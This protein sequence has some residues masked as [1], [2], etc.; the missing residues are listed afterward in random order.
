MPSPFIAAAL[1]AQTATLAVSSPDHRNEIAISRDGA[2]FSIRRDGQPVIATSPLGIELADRPAWARMTLSRRVDRAVDRNVRLVAGKSAIARDHYRQSLLTFRE[3]DG[4]RRTITLEIR[5]YDDGIALRYLMTGMSSAEVTGERTAF[6]IGSR[7][8]CLVSKTTGPHEAKFFPARIGSLAAGVR[9]D[10]PIVCTASSGRIGYAIAQADLGGY[11]GSSLV[12]DGDTLKV[13]LS[14]VPGRAQ[15]VVRAD[16]D[17]RSAWRVIMLADRPGDLIASNLIGN[18]NP[19][20]RGD[21]S[22]VRPGKAAWDWWSGPL[23]GMPA[24]MPN[25]RRFIDFAAQNRLPY[26]LIDAGWAL[27]AGPCCDALPTTDI[28]QAAPGVDMP[29][30]VRYARGRSVKLLLWVHWK[31]LSERMD[32][33]LDTYQHW[34]IAGVKVDFMERD[35]EEMV[36]FYRKLAAA[37]AR[38][39]LLLD[40]HAAY[41]PDGL[42][43]TFPNFI[44]Q[45]G[46]LGAEYNK[47][48]SEVT[49]SHN[50]SLAYTRMLLGPMDYTPGGMRSVAPGDFTVRDVAPLVKTTRGQALAMYVVY[51]SPL[52]MVADSPD[53]YAGADGFD[54]IRSVPTAWDE[55]R[56]LAGETGRSIVLARRKGS[57]WYIGAMT[58]ETPR[59]INVPLTFLAPG[60]YR[61]TIWQDSDRPTAVTRSVRDVSR[62]DELS[63]SLAGSGGAAT[64]LAPVDQVG[65]AGKPH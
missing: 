61:A 43:R 13:D 50:V 2:T 63:L 18:L 53:A 9:Y 40:L 52:Q 65:R 26:Y 16:R 34:G 5:A 35:D 32:V 51:E 31:H 37:T 8:D 36:A 42:N 7:D 21:F 57:T 58:D 3:V 12:R 47:L 15:P 64:I 25:Y 39:H 44:T 14:P 60:R 28:T 23:A 6:R 48:S 56:F 20:P 24:T 27:G 11:T 10:V 49:A 59:A 22:W 45:E 17:L 38:R 55:T 62:G 29:A 19:M 1:A 30:L 46:L 41:P 4:L 33:A 54:F